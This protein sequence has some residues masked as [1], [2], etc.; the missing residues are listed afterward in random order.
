ML[1]LVYTAAEPAAAEKEL[2]DL[3]VLG[4]KERKEVEDRQ[5]LW[6]AV[7]SVVDNRQMEGVLEVKGRGRVG[8]LVYRV[9]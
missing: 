3:E 4:E 6:E 5:C 9:D 1:G 2:R 7:K 8:F